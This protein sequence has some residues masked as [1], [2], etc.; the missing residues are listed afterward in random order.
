MPIVNN[1]AHKE[2][3]CYMLEAVYVSGMTQIKLTI[4]T[5][6]NPPAPLFSSS[7]FT[8]STYIYLKLFLIII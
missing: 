4:F 2:E 7:S 6:Y 5:G 1:V 3:L 8:Y